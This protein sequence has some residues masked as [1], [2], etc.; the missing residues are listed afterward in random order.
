MILRYFPSGCFGLGLDFIDYSEIGAFKSL[1]ENFNF[2]QK[3]SFIAESL[4][5]IIL[6]DMKCFKITLKR[7]LFLNM[8]GQTQLCSPQM[9]MFDMMKADLLMTG[10][11][12]EC[13]QSLH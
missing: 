6:L 10:L 3:M 2:I 12:S 7:I 4:N 13:S 9:S 11:V 1:N 5:I 8:K